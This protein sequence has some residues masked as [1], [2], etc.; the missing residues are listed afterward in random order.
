MHACTR[1]AHSLRVIQRKICYV[2]HQIQRRHDLGCAK[3]LHRKHVL[4]H[5]KTKAL[6]D[7]ASDIMSGLRAGRVPG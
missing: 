6:G 1:E 5:R 7:I 3:G 2:V 4:I